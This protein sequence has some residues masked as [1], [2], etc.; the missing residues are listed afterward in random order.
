M[1]KKIPGSEMEVPEGAS[2]FIN[3]SY[4]KFGR[5]R[6]V[7]RWDG[8]EWV[9]S[10][11]TREEVKYFTLKGE[12]SGLIEQSRASEARLVEVRREAQRIVR[13]RDGRKSSI[14]RTRK[15]ILEAKK[16]MREA[17]ESVENHRKAR[18]AACK[19]ERRL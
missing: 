2:A 8:H 3:G 10:S 16:A 15:R 5:G 13:T 9:F 14:Y 12:L 4:Y 7:F 11:K 1:L 19:A 18:K 6:R 17:S